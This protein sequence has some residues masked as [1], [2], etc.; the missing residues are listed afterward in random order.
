MR[1]LW[2]PNY[3][4]FTY[5]LCQSF[6]FT[7]QSLLS[8]AYYCMKS[9][10]SS[11]LHHLDQMMTGWWTVGFNQHPPPETNCNLKLN[12]IKLGIVVC[13]SVVPTSFV[14]VDS[15]VQTRFRFNLLVNFKIGPSPL[16][17]PPLHRPPPLPTL[18]HH[19]MFPEQL[20]F[21]SVDAWFKIIAK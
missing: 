8:Y 1:M 12:W 9:V 10:P 19:L 6:I 13:A 3:Y 21:F 14:A 4:N 17:A 7:S 11:V 5:I 2:L 15:F 16:L 18:D 20:I